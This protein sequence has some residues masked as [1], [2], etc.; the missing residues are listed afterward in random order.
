MTQGVSSFAEKG[1]LFAGQVMSDM[2]KRL[3]EEPELLEQAKE[4][5]KKRTGGR[6][7]ICPIPKGEGP[8]ARKKRQQ[9]QM[10]IAAGKAGESHD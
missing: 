1:M 10:N 4:D 3:L 7:Y 5:F 8:L 6:P 9:E 2:T